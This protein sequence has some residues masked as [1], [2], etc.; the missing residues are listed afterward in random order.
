MASKQKTSKP[1]VSRGEDGPQDKRKH[2][3]PLARQIRKTEQDK[4]PSFVFTDWASI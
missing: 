3:A 4:E 2:R 1:A